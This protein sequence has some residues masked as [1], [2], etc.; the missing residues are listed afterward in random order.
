MPDLEEKVA[1]LEARNA[2]LERVIKAMCRACTLR[3][4]GICNRLCQ[5]RDYNDTSGLTA[6]EVTARAEYALGGVY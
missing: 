5:G 1:Q 4:A 3:Q 2:E 6:V